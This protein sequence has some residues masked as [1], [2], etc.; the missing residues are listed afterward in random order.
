MTLEEVIKVLETM[1]KADRAF[2]FADFASQH[3]WEAACGATKFCYIIPNADFVIKFC[4]CNRRHNECE[5]EKWL[6]P[7]CFG[8]LVQ[9]PKFLDP[10]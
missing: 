10:S 3:G 2:D 7:A 5:Q 4:S 9:A 6:E 1:P 8:Q